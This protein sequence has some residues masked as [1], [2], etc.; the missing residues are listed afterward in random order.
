MDPQD[1][2]FAISETL[3]RLNNARHDIYILQG[4]LERLAYDARKLTVQEA[5]KAGLIKFNF[6]TS[7]SFKK[8]FMAGE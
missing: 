2:K 6:S 4:D 1:I 5:Y 3:E 7:A 8:T